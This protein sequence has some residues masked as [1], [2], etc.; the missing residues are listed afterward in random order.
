MT[1]SRNS[2]GLGLL[3]TMP[4]SVFPAQA[5]GMCHYGPCPASSQEF[6]CSGAA[7]SSVT[8]KKRLIT[9]SLPKDFVINFF[10]VIKPLIVQYF[11]SCLSPICQGRR[12]CQDL[13]MKCQGYFQLSGLLAAMQIIPGVLEVGSAYYFLLFPL[14][15]RAQGVPSIIVAEGGGQHCLQVPGGTTISQVLSCLRC[16]PLCILHF[17]I[18]EEPSRVSCC[19]IPSFKFPLEPRCSLRA[20]VVH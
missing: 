7:V 19:K 12:S 3:S 20:E 13:P 11:F 10:S 5:A 4:D 14:S 17:S 1:V 8:G 18:H 15:N 9:C 2:L 16:Q 6:A